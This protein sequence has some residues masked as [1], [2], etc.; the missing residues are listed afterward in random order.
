MTLDDDLAQPAHRAGPDAYATAHLLA[1]E[2]RLA[3]VKDLIQ[4]TT[5]PKLLPT[6]LIGKQR[7]ARWADV[8]EGFLRWMLRQDGMEVDLRWNAE[9]ELKRRA[10]Q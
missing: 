1:A 8:E 2:L 7:G 9:R 6:L 10:G 3:T 5:E 4:W